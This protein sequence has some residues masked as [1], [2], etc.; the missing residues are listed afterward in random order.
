MDELTQ[1]NEN[2]DMKQ[3]G[4]QNTKARLE[5]SLKKEWKTR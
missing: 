5:D 2:N 4:I 3:G 1:P